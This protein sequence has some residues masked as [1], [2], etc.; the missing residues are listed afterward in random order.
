MRAALTV[1]W[2]CFPSP[3]QPAEPRRLGPAG[4]AVR[5]SRSLHRACGSWR[6]F[7]FRPE[8]RAVSAARGRDRC[9]VRYLGCS[10][11]QPPMGSGLVLAQLASQP[12]AQVSAQ[13]R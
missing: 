3:P 6:A 4:A 9:L 2:S 5:E 10:A 8:R 12:R 1:L 7:F 11:R 13:E